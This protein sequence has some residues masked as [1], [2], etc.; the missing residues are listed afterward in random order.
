MTASTGLEKSKEAR[1]HFDIYAIFEGPQ[2]LYFGDE[3]Q[4]NVNLVEQVKLEG[5]NGE[6]MKKCYLS[7]TKRRGVERRSLIWAPSSTGELL[8]DKQKCGI[9]ETCTQIDCPICAIFGGLQPGKSTL[10]GRLTHGGGVAIQTLDPE[11]KQ[12]AMHPAE[13]KKSTSP[14]PYRREYNEPGLLY[15]IYNHLLSVTESEFNAAAYAFLDSL[16]R[17]GAGNPKGVRLYEESGAPLLVVDRYVSPLGKRPV[18]SP[19]IHRVDEAI[20]EFKR[21]ASTVHGTTH[22]DT[23]IQLPRFDRKIG[24]AALTYLQNCADQF[25]KDH[26]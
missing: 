10:I 14:T 1:Q 19:H 2:E 6:K 16:A 17:V 26:L 15:P 4:V 12:R 24:D 25:A 13:I 9:P 21:L 22:T 5:P 20:Q 11:E 3:V 8:G 18:L 7:P 23:H